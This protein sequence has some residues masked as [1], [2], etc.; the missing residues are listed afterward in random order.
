MK[1]IVFPGNCPRLAP[2][3]AKYS[4]RWRDG[5]QVVAL[6]YRVNQAEYEILSTDR[7]PELIRMVN[8]VKEHFADNSGGAFY[9]NEWRQVLVPVI[10]QRDYYYAGE[11]M[12]NLEFDF[13]GKKLSGRPV[14]L[15]GVP[16]KPGDR[17][18][19]PH[20]GIP[21][22]LMAGG[23]DIYFEVEVSSTRIR[24]VRLSEFVGPEAAK[25]M[26]SRVR[27]IRDERGGRFYVNE[28]R[29]MFTPVSSEG[30]IS[31]IYIGQLDEGAPWFAKPVLQETAD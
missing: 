13:E 20:P 14:S 6:M 22:K 11:Y 19:G 25:E 18:D 27:A 8:T 10:G 9:I 28:W 26:A 24:T 31:Y 15:D 3:E 1:P 7:H 29:A 30:S 12:G 17:W 21:Y 16:L 5:R 4:V 23:R 2:R